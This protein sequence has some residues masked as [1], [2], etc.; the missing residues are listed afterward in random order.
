MFFAQQIFDL[1]CLLFFWLLLILEI[2]I[3]SYYKY[4]LGFAKRKQ[5][6]YNHK[7]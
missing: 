2:V 1:E 5:S 4:Q 7:Y 3:I 6:Y